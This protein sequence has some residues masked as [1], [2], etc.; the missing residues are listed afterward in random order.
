M[1]VPLGLIG[2][3]PAEATSILGSVSTAHKYNRIR[4]LKDS[5][6]AIVGYLVGITWL[7]FVIYYMLDEG[8][9][10]YSNPL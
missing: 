8:W 4:I 9:I 6:G 1:S 10:I 5:I 2:V 3:Y 7:I